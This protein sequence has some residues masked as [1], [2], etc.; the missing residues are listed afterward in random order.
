MES[1]NITIDTIL[2]I[3]GGI[4]IVGGAW[5]VICRWISPAF[6]ITRRVEILERKADNDFRMLVGLSEMNSAQNRAVVRLINHMING[7][8]VKE[9][10][11]TQKELLDTIMEQNFKT[12]EK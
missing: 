11:E 8:G 6:K 10:Q 3:A 7:N 5:A 4:S 9:M 1:M 12:S 2:A